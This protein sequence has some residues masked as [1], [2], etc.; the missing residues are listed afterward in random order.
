MQPTL[1]ELRDF[2]CG[3]PVRCLIPDTNL[4]CVVR[5]DDVFAQ[6]HLPSEVVEDDLLNDIYSDL[7]AN[8][9]EEWKSSAEWGFDADQLS[10]SQTARILG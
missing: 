7:S 6:S 4:S 5:R 9:P 10:S 2:E 1:D 3:E 8:A